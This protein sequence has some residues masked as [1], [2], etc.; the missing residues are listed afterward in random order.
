MRAISTT[1]LK[2]HNLTFIDFRE[3]FPNFQTKSRETLEKIGKA[4]TIS[5]IKRWNSNE[6]EE[7]WKNKNVKCKYCDKSIEWKHKRNKT[8]CSMSC[9]ISYKNQQTWANADQNHP[10]RN[11]RPVFSSRGEKELFVYLCETY[12]EMKW[13]RSKKIH[14]EDREY[15]I[16]IF[17]EVLNLY[18]EYDGK[19]HFEIIYGQSRL[20]SIRIRDSIV[21][22]Y[23]SSDGR[24]LIR[25]DEKT[26]RSEKNWKELLDESLK[27]K[28][29]LI[30]IYSIETKI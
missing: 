13:K 21:E 1:H 30:K 25:I 26:F 15:V 6:K 19:I 29:R 24:K 14:V 2:S 5:N 17:S 18:V 27:S 10:W 16:D 23:C 8:F 7:E 11:K 3:A 9:S 28:K 4:S 12:P 20:D 22:E